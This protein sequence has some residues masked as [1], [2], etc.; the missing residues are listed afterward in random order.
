MT[1]I[2]L[3]RHSTTNDVDNQL[4]GRIDTP[5]NEKGRQ[6]AQELAVTLSGQPIKGVYSSPLLRTMQT[7]EPLADRLRLTVRSM[8][9]LIQ[10]DYGDW[11][12]KPFWELQQDPEWRRYVNEPGG[13]IPGGEKVSDVVQ[14]VSSGLMQIAAQHPG[15]QM[16]IAV[17]HGSV[18]R[19]AIAHFL[20]MEPGNA[21]RLKIY[22]GSVSVLRIVG[23]EIG[24][25]VSMNR[26][27]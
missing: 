10:V 2:L 4:A 17:S 3:M 5:L 24:V 19:F 25:L 27:F 13:Q 23:D 16:V 9:E 22:P 14:R 8:P 18:I 7:A 15:D 1:E 26:L 12:K 20:G 21:N 6:R 11:E